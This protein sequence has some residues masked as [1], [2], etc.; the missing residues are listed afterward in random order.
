MELEPESV[1]DYNL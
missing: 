1:T